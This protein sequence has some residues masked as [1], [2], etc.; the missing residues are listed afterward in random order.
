MLWLGKVKCNCQCLGRKH[1]FLRWF[2]CRHLMK[3]PLIETWQGENTSKIQ[4]G[5][6]ETNSRGKQST[7]WGKAGGGHSVTT[8]QGETWSCEA[9]AAQWTIVTEGPSYSQKCG[10]KVRGG[11]DMRV[12][13]R[14]VRSGEVRGG[15][16]CPNHFL[17]P[18]HPTG[19]KPP[20][21]Y[22]P[23]GNRS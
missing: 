16:K 17:S 1:N 9:E 5:H 7:P 3:G 4:V 8:A 2:K 14:E 6:P 18:F 19:N 13:A 20:L 15:K 21:P 23:N 10:A 22:Q 12:G 11:E